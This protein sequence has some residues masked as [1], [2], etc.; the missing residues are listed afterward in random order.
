MKNTQ[1]TTKESEKKYSIIYADPPWLYGSKGPRSGKFANLDYNS[2]TIGDL[3][4]MDIKS[5]CEKNCALHMWVTGSFIDDAIKVGKAWGFKFIRM[6]KVWVKK[7]ESGKPHAACGPWGMSDCEFILLFVRGSMCNKQIGKRNQYVAT[8]EAYTGK[9]SEKPALFRD[10]IDARYQDGL[11]KLEMF[12]RYPVDGWDV[13]GN[14][15]P[16]SIKIGVK[17]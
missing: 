2:M 15:A 16:N 5:I 17:P 7:K 6:D 4:N 3:C 11:N 9:H 12:A 8:V 14:E 10:Q 1:S 13:F